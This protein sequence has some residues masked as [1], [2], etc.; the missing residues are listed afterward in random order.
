M[1]KALAASDYAGLGGTY[2]FDPTGKRVEAHTYVYRYN[3][4]GS[5]ELID[6]V[7]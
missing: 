5:P 3:K 4:D 7:R 6:S 1:A 2:R